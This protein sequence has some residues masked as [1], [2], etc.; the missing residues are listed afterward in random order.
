[1]SRRFNIIVTV[2]IST[3]FLG[4]TAVFLAIVCAGSGKRVKTFGLSAVYYVCELFGIDY[5]FTPTVTEYSDVLQWEILLPSDWA[6]FTASAKEY[7]ALL[8]GG[9]NFAGY[10]AESRRRDARRGKGHCCSVAPASSC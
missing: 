8:I 3:I 9:E 4:V 1:M 7:F 10:W 2:V 5:S 6:G